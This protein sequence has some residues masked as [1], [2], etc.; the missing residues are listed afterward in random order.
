M[1]WLSIYVYITKVE[2]LVEDG[3]S[4]FLTQVLPPTGIRFRQNFGEQAEHLL[5]QQAGAKAAKGG[6]TGNYR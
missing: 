1:K 5:N 6:R 3:G 2:S 4:A